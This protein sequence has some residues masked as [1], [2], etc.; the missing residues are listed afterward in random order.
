MSEQI[1]LDS[2][3]HLEDRSDMASALGEKTFFNTK[4]K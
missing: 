2:L 4:I 1:S 3:C